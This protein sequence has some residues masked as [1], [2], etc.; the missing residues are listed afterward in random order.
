[1][2]FCFAE[3]YFITT[4]QKSFIPAILTVVNLFL[5]WRGVFHFSYILYKVMYCSVYMMKSSGRKRE[6]L[7]PQDLA[8]LRRLMWAINC[9]ACFMGVFYFVNSTMTE[10]PFELKYY[11][12]AVFLLLFAVFP[13]LAGIAVTRI[14]TTIVNLLDKELLGKNNT[15][16]P[17]AVRMR[18]WLV[19]TKAVVYCIAIF[20][21]GVGLIGFMPFLFPNFFFFT[22]SVWF[23]GNVCGIIAVLLLRIPLD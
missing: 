7:L 13:V 16:P 17:A 19:I 21:A 3:V 1:M 11:L 4:R 2:L 18:R 14:F 20:V 23:C 5:F 15:H 10:K 6:I 9:F 22:S 8:R 12:W